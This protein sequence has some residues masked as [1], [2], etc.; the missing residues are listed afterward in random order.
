MH[1]SLLYQR[2]PCYELRLLCFGSEGKRQLQRALGHKSSTG[3]QFAFLPLLSEGGEQLLVARRA[4]R[5]SR[6]VPP[7]TSAGSEA[8]FALETKAH[9]SPD[10]N[11]FHLSY[12]YCSIS[13]F[14][15]YTL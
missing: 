13:V 5:K 3:L 9:Q 7:S 8:P 12:E 14:T 10:I 2:A 1:T 15:N 11:T 6:E 4:L